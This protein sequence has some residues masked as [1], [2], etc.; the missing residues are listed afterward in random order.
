MPNQTL[1]LNT[2][3]KLF[4]MRK[5]YLSILSSFLFVA[6]GL[7]QT[8]V[9]INCTGAEGS[10]NSGY[11]N[12]TGA[13][14]SDGNLIVDGN[15]TP[16]KR[17]WASFNLSSIP[18]GSIINS[19]TLK[20]T[21]TSNNSSGNPN[22]I[23][24]FSGIPSSTAGATLYTNAGSGT[25]FNNSSW[26]QNTT[27]SLGF[28]AAGTAFISGA[29]GGNTN[30]GFVRGGGNSVF[31]I[32]GYPAV[33]ASQPQLVINYSPSYRS[34]FISM[35]SGS[36]TWC[37][38]D[39]RNITVTVKNIGTATWASAGSG[40]NI[41]LK[42]DEDADYGSAPNN[43]PRQPVQGGAP[44]GPVAPGPLTGCARR[45]RSAPRRCG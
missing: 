19:V 43:I 21:V 12:S 20:F 14:K 2:F 17:G 1:L 34:Q 8:T 6:A 42:W 9:T 7:A 26:T 38:S 10:F 3:I 23:F 15:N 4:F 27:N 24:G 40:M 39:V 5:I 45:P 18:A 13:I 36:S 28:N 25:N 41:G 11:V 16:L 32:N 37:K 35:S 22:G 31:N 30:I 33:A 29:L 44:L